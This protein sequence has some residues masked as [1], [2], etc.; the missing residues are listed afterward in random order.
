VAVFILVQ[1]HD[2][3][4]GK[5]DF[6]GEVAHQY[7]GGSRRCDA[8]NSRIHFDAIRNP[9]D[10][11]GVTRHNANVAGGSVAAAKQDKVDADGE[12]FLNCCARILRGGFRRRRIHD[13]DRS[14]PSSLQDIAPHSIGRS[15][16][17]DHG[18]IWCAVEQMLELTERL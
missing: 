7:F 10:R 1:I 15:K 8:E 17:F 9:E 18:W 5:P 14:E 13:L 6:V 11:R 16:P 4:A 2:L 12:K 3:D